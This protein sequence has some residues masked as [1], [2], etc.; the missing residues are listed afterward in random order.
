MRI[1]ERR[2]QKVE[3]GGW[4]AYWAV[5]KQFDALEARMGGFPAKRYYHPMEKYTTTI[6]WEREWESF[7]T[8]E[9]TYEKEWADPEIGKIVTV[10][11]GES[12][13]FCFL[14]RRPEG[15]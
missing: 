15:D 2:T 11:L 3:K 7:T 9:A 14:A 13:E 5:E 6:V 8:M 4:D 10:H 1:I 12:L